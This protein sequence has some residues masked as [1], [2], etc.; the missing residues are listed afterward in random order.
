[1][2]K[3]SEQAQRQPSPLTAHNNR[4]NNH[5]NNNDDNNNNNN[6]NVPVNCPSAGT[7]SMGIWEDHIHEK[8]PQGCYSCRDPTQRF[9][10][11]SGKLLLVTYYSQIQSLKNSQLKSF[12]I[13]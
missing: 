10:S 7:R 3:H 11:N 9:S 13:F 5:H 6:N 4:P 1:M 12:I 2:I 8:E